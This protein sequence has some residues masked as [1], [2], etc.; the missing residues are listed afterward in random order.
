MAGIALGKTLVDSMEGKRPSSLGGG[1][2]HL[3]LS[4]QDFKRPLTLF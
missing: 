1:V 4:R 2:F 3:P